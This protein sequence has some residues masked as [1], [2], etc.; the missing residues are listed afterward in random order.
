MRTLK[1]DSKQYYFRNIFKNIPT[2]TI[3]K[4][5]LVKIVIIKLS[6]YASESMHIFFT[7]VVCTHNFHFVLLRFT[8]ESVVFSGLPK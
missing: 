6:Y 3:F 2:N 8:D 5:S 4:V 7:H 1:F